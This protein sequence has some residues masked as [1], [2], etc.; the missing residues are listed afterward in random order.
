MGVERCLVKHQEIF[1]KYPRKK[2]DIQLLA[3][4]MQ[5]ANKCFSK[6]NFLYVNFK[7]IQTSYL[8]KN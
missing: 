3:R 8:Q 4:E 1:G 2:L 6:Y 5:S 7:L